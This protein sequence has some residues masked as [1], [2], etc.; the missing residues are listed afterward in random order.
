MWSSIKGSY[1]TMISVGVSAFVL[2]SRLAS[3][4][5]VGGRPRDACSLSF[6]RT[7]VELFIG[8]HL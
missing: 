2:N 4:T 5:V 7:Y 8:A 6:S 3:E 1:K